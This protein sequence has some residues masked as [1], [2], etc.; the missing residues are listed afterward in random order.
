MAG[1]TV[2]INAAGSWSGIYVEASYIQVSGFVVVGAN[3]S[4]SYNTAVSYESDPGDHPDYNG[5]C[6][7]VTPPSSTGP[8]PTHVKILENVAKDCPGGGIATASADY[9]TI[10]GNVVLN[11]S[12]YSAYGTSGISTFTDYDS[13]PKDTSSYRVIITDNDVYNN[14]EFIPWVSAGRITDGEGIVIDSNLNN[15]YDNSVPYGPYGGRTLVANNVINGNG[16]AAIEV[17]E[18]AHVDVVNNSTYGNLVGSTFQ[19]GPLGSGEFLIYTASDVRALNNIFYAVGN[20]APVFDYDT[21][22]QCYIDN[23]VYYGGQPN[24]WPNGIPTS[25]NDVHSHFV[26]PNYVSISSNPATVN[27]QI[28]SPYTNVLSNGTGWLAPTT[29]ITGKTRVVSSSYTVPV[30]AYTYP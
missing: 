28:Q 15:A 10:S 14:M 22:P 9:L 26:N 12:W 20:S 13:N 23:N 6:I 21:C 4:L 1:Q 19:N 17:F 11:N 25:T 7:S 24:Q 18:S 8:Y 30:G 3:A 29:D 2:T 27:L 5:N 16:S